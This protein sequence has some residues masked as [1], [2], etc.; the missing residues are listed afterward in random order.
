[1]NKYTRTVKQWIDGDADLFRQ[2]QSHPQDVEIIVRAHAPML[3]GELFG[4]L[5]EL[6]LQSVDWSEIADLYAFPF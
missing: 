5:L 2:V 4:D 3:D 6:A 1:M